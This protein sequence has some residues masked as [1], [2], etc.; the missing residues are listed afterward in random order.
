MEYQ[1]SWAFTAQAK[2]CRCVCKLARQPWDLQLRAAECR[3]VGMQLL[4]VAVSGCHLF[5]ELLRVYVL[6]RSESLWN[7]LC[8]IFS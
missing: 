7:C 3:L 2:V 8:F 4:Q 5:L 1:G 6:P